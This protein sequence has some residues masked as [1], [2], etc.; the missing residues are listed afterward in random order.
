[1][2]LVGEIVNVTADE[3]I[4]TEGKIDPAKLKPITFDPVNNTYIGLGN[5][6][7]KAFADGVKLK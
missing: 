4:L 6:V 2:V 1:M 7:G 5:I 3:S